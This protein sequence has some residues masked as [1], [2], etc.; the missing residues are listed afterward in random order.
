MK[1]IRKR[2]SMA[3]EAKA[4]GNSAF[5]ARKFN[6]AVKFFSEAIEPPCHRAEWNSNGVILFIFVTFSLL[7]SGRTRPT[8]PFP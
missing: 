5:S 6:E 4:K 1:Q 2:W 8:L 3:E 7:A